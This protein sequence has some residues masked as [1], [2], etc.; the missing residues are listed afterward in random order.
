MVSE[1][2]DSSQQVTGNLEGYIQNNNQYVEIQVATSDSC[3]KKKIL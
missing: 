1:I 3:I 2:F